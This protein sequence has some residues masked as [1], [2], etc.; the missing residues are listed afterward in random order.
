MSQL[1]ADDAV[2]KLQEPCHFKWGENEDG[3]T[4]NNLGLMMVMFVA[5]FIPSSSD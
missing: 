1:A 4:T 2:E 3:P 5:I